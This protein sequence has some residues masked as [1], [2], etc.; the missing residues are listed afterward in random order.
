MPHLCKHEHL[1]VDVRDETKLVEAILHCQPM[2]TE[3]D[4]LPYLHVDDD[5]G[6]GLEIVI[7]RL[8][9]MFPT[10]AAGFYTA[11]RE[12]VITVVKRIHPNI[13]RLK[14]LNRLVG[15]QQISRPD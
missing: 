4:A 12:L 1:R 14:L 9:T 6:L 11:E 8:R 5:H 13:S 3:M 2:S 15:V 10:D 7:Q